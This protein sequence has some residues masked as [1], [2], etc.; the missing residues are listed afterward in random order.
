M[1]QSKRHLAKTDLIIHSDK[2]AF[3]EVMV[4]NLQP[5]EAVTRK[6]SAEKHISCS[7]II[8]GIAATYCNSNW[9]NQHPQ[10]E[11]DIPNVYAFP[12]NGK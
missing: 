12:Q 11:P 3:I 5:F 7:K 10:S 8:L 6:T 1:K 4:N 2:N 9:Y